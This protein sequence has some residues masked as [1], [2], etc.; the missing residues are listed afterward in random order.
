M[1]KPHRKRKQNQSVEAGQPFTPEQELLFKQLNDEHLGLALCFA[2]RRGISDPEFVVNG[3]MLEALLSFDPSKG[4]FESLLL[5][6]IFF[7]GIDSS[8]KEQRTRNLLTSLYDDLKIA[9][10][11]IVHNLWLADLRAELNEALQHLSI[12][13]Q[14]LIRL[15]YEKGLSLKEIAELL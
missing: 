14:Q 9:D 6:I 13:D 10:Q 7:D 8:R 3:A 5:S 15:K 4:S 11:A 12:K 1:K 2:R